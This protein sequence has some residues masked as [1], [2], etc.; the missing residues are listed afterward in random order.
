M[1]QS[2]Y[3]RSIAAARHE[4]YVADMSD[5]TIG[6]G[7]LGDLANPTRFMALADRLVP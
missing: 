1:R 4:V 7:R 2:E 5:T 3:G 6:T